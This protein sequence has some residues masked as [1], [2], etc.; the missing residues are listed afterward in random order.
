MKKL[1][2]AIIAALLLLCVCFTFFL[3]NERRGE[4]V[5]SIKDAKPGY[6]FKASFYSGATPKVTR[7]MD[8]C[9][10]LLGKEN[11]SFHIK[12]SDGNLII[13]ADKQENSA[14]VISHIKKMCKGI[15]DILIQN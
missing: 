9:T 4:T 11:A 3:Q 15:S 6:T 14:M 13:T 8:S 10:A 5:L 7:Y 1:T 2:P 12:I